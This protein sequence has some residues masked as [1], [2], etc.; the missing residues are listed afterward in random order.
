MKVLCIPGS[1]GP[2]FLMAGMIFGRHCLVRQGGDANINGEAFGD[3][4]VVVGG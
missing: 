1:G 4:F 2:I 3:G